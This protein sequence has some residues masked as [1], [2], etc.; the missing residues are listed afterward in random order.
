MVQQLV[1]AGSAW[2]QDILTAHLHPQLV[3]MHHH[4]VVLKAL[5]PGHMPHC[6]MVQQL[7][8]LPP[9]ARY[10]WLHHLNVMAHVVGRGRGL[11][12]VGRQSQLG[13]A[14]LSG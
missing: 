3:Q 7:A 11:G 2:L 6:W 1:P 5:A 13:C 14:Q 4:V 12:Q 8:M 10:L 9:A